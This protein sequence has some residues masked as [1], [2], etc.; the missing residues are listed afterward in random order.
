MITALEA[1]ERLKEGN[2]RF[3]S[4]QGGR[5]LDF[6]HTR[7]Q[8][9]VDEQAPFAIVLGC[10]DS[11]VPLELIFD[12]GMGD[13]FVIRVAG[14]I[15]GPSQ[16]GSVEFAASKFGTPL[17]VVLGHSQCGAVT[18][19]LEDVLSPTGSLSPNLEYVVD[20]VRPAVQ[21]VLENEPGGDR[22]WLVGQAVRENVRLAAKRLA[23]DSEVL[24]S[25]V[26]DG[27]L[28][29]VCAEYSLESGAVDFFE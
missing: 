8:Q 13:L 17:V 23:H 1:L 29:V 20:Q 28:M 10:S 11:R 21:S 16:A 2:Q 26:R 6:E 4:G 19:T 27:R 3:I 9:L 7:R 5:D 25:R 24:E 22:N 12:Q 18:A 14:N 15:A